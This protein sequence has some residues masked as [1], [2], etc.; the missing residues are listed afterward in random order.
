MYTETHSAD[1]Y[2]RA[3]SFSVRCILIVQRCTL[4]IALYSSALH[5]V[6]LHIVHTTALHSVHTKALHI[7]HSAAQ[8]CAAYY[9]AACCAYKY[10]YI[11][12]LALHIVHANCAAQ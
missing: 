10:L 7:V 3:A 6:A 4:C 8:Q 9:S 11:L 2:T 12:S 5:V 1:T